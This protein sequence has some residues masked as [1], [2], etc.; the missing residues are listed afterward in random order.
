MSG[1]RQARRAPGPAEIAALL[2][3]PRCGART[4]TGAA[5][6]APA[7]RD[8]R[9]CRKHGGGKGSGGQRGNANALQHGA[10]SADMRAQRRAVM[11]YVRACNRAMKDWG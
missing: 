8:K 4:R 7:V 9:R 3:S 2:G 5:C 1:E 10:Y 6:R 11:D